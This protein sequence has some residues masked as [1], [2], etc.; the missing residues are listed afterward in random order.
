MRHEGAAGEELRTPVWQRAVEGRVQ[1]ASDSVQGHRVGQL[2]RVAVRRGR[3]FRLSPARAQREKR[4]A[5][6]DA[7]DFLAEICDG[8]ARRALSALE[9]GVLSIARGVGA[10]CL[11]VVP[12]TWPRIVDPCENGI[13]GTLRGACMMERAA[14]A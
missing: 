5:A 14:I 13:G 4:A 9:V 1:R 6:E 7:L 11:P 10:V 2:P 8:D 12:E 3:F